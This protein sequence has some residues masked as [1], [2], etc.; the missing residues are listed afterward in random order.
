MASFS[1]RGTLEPYLTNRA[2]MLLRVLFP[3]VAYLPL[4]LSFAMISLPFEA[5]FGTR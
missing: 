4:S 3:A 5:P 2:V 1:I